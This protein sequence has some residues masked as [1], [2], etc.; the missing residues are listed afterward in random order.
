MSSVVRYSLAATVLA[1]GL[2]VSSAFI[3][4]FFFTIRH[5]KEITV[6][7]FAQASVTS[8]IGKIRFTISIRREKMEEAYKDLT[9]QLGEILARIEAEAPTDLIVEKDNPTFSERYKLNDE[10]KKTHEIEDYSGSGMVTLSSSDVD[11][12][13]ALGPTINEFIGKGYDLHVRSPE[14]LVSDLT[15]LKQDLL[16][17]AT[18]DGYRRAE[19]MARHSGAMV[20]TL[21]AAHQGVFQITEPNSTET[22]G[23]GMYDTSTIE[24]SMKAVVTL[25]YSVE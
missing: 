1:L 12:I 11:W 10:G 8:D 14:F 25:E 18:A 21:R 20:G 22:S 4:K 3:S 6:K 7:G 13:Q 16:E 9:A 5:E 2:V 15:P 24:K 17:K 19:L 23:Y